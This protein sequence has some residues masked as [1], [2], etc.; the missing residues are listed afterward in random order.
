M[1]V[2]IS[3]PHFCTNAGKGTHATISV[4]LNSDSEANCDFCGWELEP[5][6]E[7]E[8]AI[9]TMLKVFRDFYNTKTL[10]CRRDDESE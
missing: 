10:N 7:I 3:V 9:T 4:N 2:R 8:E 5:E 1:E 6:E